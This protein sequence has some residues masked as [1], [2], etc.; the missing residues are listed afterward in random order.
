M[1]VYNKFLPITYSAEDIEDLKVYRSVLRD[2]RSIGS[3]IT[4]KKELLAKARRCAVFDE[5]RHHLSVKRETAD[6]K[7][8]VHL[9]PKGGYLNLGH[10]E[11]DE[12]MREAYDNQDEAGFGE[13]ILNHVGNKLIN[14]IETALDEDYVPEDVE[15]YLNERFSDDSFPEVF[16]LDEAALD[17]D[18]HLAVSDLAQKMQT[19][20]ARTDTPTLSAIEFV[21][22]VMMPPK[23]FLKIVE[24]MF[25]QH[26]EDGV[27]QTTFFKLIVQNGN[28]GLKPTAYENG[29]SRRTPSTV[30]AITTFD[31]V[32][33]E[34]EMMQAVAPRADVIERFTDMYRFALLSALQA[35]P[36]FSI[37][38]DPTPAAGR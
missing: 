12:D 28:I 30:V 10:F 13:Y 35:V 25:E 7:F 21:D 22:R 15:S 9:S 8:S 32:V 26:L 27:E 18:L 4:N 29:V 1:K 6:G 33:Y 24:D 5:V 34:Y 17:S 11:A 3:L 37:R 20:V 31:D 23:K 19:G 16:V 14:A 38:F 36:S 2:L